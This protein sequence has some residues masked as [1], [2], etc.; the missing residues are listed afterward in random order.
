MPCVGNL[1]EW[2]LHMVKTRRK[3]TGTT[4]PRDHKGTF[5]TATR[6]S[7]YGAGQPVPCHKTAVLLLPWPDPPADEKIGDPL[8][9]QESVS[10]HNPFQS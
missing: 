4:K 5:K 8:D 7:G 2:L 6:P 1:P 3:Q 10:K 9:A